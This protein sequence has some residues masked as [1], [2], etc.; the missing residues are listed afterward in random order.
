MAASNSLEMVKLLVAKGA[1]CTSKDL[2][3]S[4]KHG[5]KDIAAFLTNQLN[6]HQWNP[7]LTYLL[8]ARRTPVTPSWPLICGG[9]ARRSSSW[10]WRGSWTMTGVIVIARTKWKP[11]V[12]YKDTA[13]FSDTQCWSLLLDLLKMNPDSEAVRER[14]RTSLASTCVKPLKEK[15][16]YAIHVAWN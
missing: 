13:K 6:W 4:H 2:D 9:G 12:K 16:H 10:T 7:S 14:L 1:I 5:R 11:M 15:A 3:L 8:T